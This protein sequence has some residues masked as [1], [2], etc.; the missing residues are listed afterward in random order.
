MEGG[1]RLGTGDR[2]RA[3][4][5]CGEGGVS[6]GKRPRGLAGIHA[7]RM[8]LTIGASLLGSWCSTAAPA[9]SCACRAAPP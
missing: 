7:L 6:G 9:D 1:S 2:K 4:E 8:A 3:R 5:G